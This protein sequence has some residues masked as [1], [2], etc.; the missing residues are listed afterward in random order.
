MVNWFVYA[1]QINIQKDAFKHQV[2]A[3]VLL[4]VVPRARREPRQRREPFVFSFE[5]VDGLEHL[6]IG[7]IRELRGIATTG[8]D[9]P[10]AW[11]TE[12]RIEH[13]GAGHAEFE[14]IVTLH[15]AGLFV[16]DEILQEAREDSRDHKAPMLVVDM[17]PSAEA[18][19]RL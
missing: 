3:N 5:P 7:T 2:K 13:I 14:A 19:P 6:L 10:C 4:R 17:D 12:P 8:V 11:R 16:P 1:P 9:F 15:L 18:I